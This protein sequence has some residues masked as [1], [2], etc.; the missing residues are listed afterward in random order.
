MNT[1]THPSL[2]S[3]I[4]TCSTK[5]SP[6]CAVAICALLT[7]AEFARF[8]QNILNVLLV[9]YLGC[10]FSNRTKY[11]ESDA[12]VC[13]IRASKLN[14]RSTPSQPVWL[15][16]EPL[17]SDWPLESL[18]F[19][20]TLCLPL[21]PGQILLLCFCYP[22]LRSVDFYRIRF[23]VGSFQ[24]VLSVLFPFF[25]PGALITAQNSLPGPVIASFLLIYPL[26]CC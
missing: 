7:Y 14:T 18:L 26:S 24:H 12:K 23:S 9:E 4:W 8:F 21:F 5:R 17:V 16:G 1:L 15:T 25:N 13:T 10:Q 20:L 3:E 22:L 11:G 19:L 6:P 2:R